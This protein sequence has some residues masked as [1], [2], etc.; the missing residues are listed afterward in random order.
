LEVIGVGDGHVCLD[1]SFVRILQHD[2]AEKVGV[3]PG[4]YVRFEVTDTGTGMPS[5]V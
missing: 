2:Q 4:D 5:E 1:V 3:V